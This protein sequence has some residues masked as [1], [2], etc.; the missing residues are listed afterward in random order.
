MR[1]INRVTFAQARHSLSGLFSDTE[2]KLNVK[3]AYYRSN[4][5]QI[6]Y[7]P[8]ARPLTGEERLARFYL[9]YETNN[10]FPSALAV[11]L[12]ATALLLRRNIVWRRPR[13]KGTPA[14]ESD[15]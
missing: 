9:L 7:W 10:I 11:L 8:T 5:A 2:A 13:N 3:A 14:L 1:A 4:Y 6:I 12:A 15:V